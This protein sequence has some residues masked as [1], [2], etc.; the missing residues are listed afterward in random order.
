ML[1]NFTLSIK[2]M[3]V[4]FDIHVKN[5]NF[6]TNML[7]LEI[8]N[9]GKI[10]VSAIAITIPPQE[11]IRIKGPN[12]NIV[13]DLDSNEYTT[14]DFEVSGSGNMNLE[15]SYTDA[16]DVRRS[17]NKTINFDPLYFQDRKA[18]EKKVSPVTYS[19]IAAVV[20]IIILWIYR[21]YKK[22]KHRRP[23]S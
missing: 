19:V 9:L 22:R 23:V 15:I 16:I 8:L 7:T 4:D 17:I 13:G 20:I 1:N 10:T 2:E 6:N 14:A 11:N 3:K 18:D 21:S 12:K 5:Y